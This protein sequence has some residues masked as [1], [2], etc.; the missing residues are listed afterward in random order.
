MVL[1]SF[2]SLERTTIIERFVTSE[3]G[4]SEGLFRRQPRSIALGNE[5]VGHG[6]CCKWEATLLRKHIV[7]TLSGLMDVYM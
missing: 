6:E 2:V 5:S 4:T 3:R 7:N 1:H